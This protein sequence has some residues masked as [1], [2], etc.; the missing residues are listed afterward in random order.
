MS[1]AFTVTKDAE[2]FLDTLA[3]STSE[4]YRNMLAHFDRFLQATG[5]TPED[6]SP[7]IFAEILRL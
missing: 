6:L 2:D 7:A 4:G 1:H 5:K 3:A